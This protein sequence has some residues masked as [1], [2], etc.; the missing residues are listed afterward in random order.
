MHS[1]VLQSLLSKTNYLLISIIYRYNQR[2]YKI[3]RVDFSM[4]PESTFDKSGTQ[5]R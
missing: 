4:S 2:T 5:V 3:E 1:R